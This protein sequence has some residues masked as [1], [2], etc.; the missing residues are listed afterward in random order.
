MKKSTAL[1]LRELKKKKDSSESKFPTERN[2][3]S[4]FA[5]QFDAVTPIEIESQSSDAAAA[6]RAQCMDTSI[7]ARQ[8]KQQLAWHRMTLFV[9]ILFS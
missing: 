9:V 1:K 7:F 5:W 6:E 8:C 3:W 2:D 4:A